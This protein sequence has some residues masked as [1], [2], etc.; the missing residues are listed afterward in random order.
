M[1]LQLRPNW[2]PTSYPA[3]TKTFADAWIEAT[4][5]ECRWCMLFNHPLFP[6]QRIEFHRPKELR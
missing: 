1:I 3:P 5:W 2:P 6:N 4:M